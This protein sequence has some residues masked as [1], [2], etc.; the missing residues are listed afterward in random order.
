M[1]VRITE[2]AGICSG[3][4]PLIHVL[5]FYRARC[6]QPSP[7]QAAQLGRVCG[8]GGE[9]DQHIV[10]TASLDIRLQI[11]G[12]EGQ[13]AAA[14]LVSPNARCLVTG[15][16]GTLEM[17][18]GRHSPAQPSQPRQAAEDGDMQHT[19]TA[20]NLMLGTQRYLQTHRGSSALTIV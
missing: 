1:K 18:S 9:Y 15:Y 2:L 16:G 17:V 7:A 8:A 5:R 10:N 3:F 4:Q 13:S 14:C 6:A 11:W 12:D 19:A 20:D